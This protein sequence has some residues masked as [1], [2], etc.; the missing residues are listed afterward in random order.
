[1]VKFLFPATNNGSS[2]SLE[3]KSQTA[4]VFLD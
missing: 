1:M 4:L 3:S 2:A